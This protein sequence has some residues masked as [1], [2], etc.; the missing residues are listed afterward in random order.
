M[1]KRVFDVT[2]SFFLLLFLSPILLFVAVTVYIFLGKPVLFKQKR[3]GYG[4]KIFTIYKFRTMKNTLGKDGHPLADHKRLTR[5]GKILRNFSLDELPQLINIL[6][7]DMSFVGPRPLLVEYLP[8]YDKNQIR[9]HLVRPGITGWAQVNGRN[10][11]EWDK[12]FQLDI[13]YVDHHSFLLDLKIIW[14]TFIRVIKCTNIA[15]EDH[16]SMPLF[17]GNKR[18]ERS[19]RDA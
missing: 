6:K 14:L 3:V 18:D 12:K 1:L 16:A 8:L 9:R 11:I 15:Y 4:N 13:W 19:D 5:L 17:K 10:A 7:G 2:L